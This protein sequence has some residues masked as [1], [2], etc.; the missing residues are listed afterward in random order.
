MPPTLMDTNTIGRYTAEHSAHSTSLIYLCHCVN[1]KPASF[2]HQQDQAFTA[3]FA[4][5]KPSTL[6]DH[7]SPLNALN[8][9]DASVILGSVS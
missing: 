4:L 5:S 1:W 8:F 6:Q 2:G 3:S 7:C 9:G